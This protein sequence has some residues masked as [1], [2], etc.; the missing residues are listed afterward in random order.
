MSEK[1]KN[2]QLAELLDEL[3]ERLDE[4]DNAIRPDLPTDDYGVGE[5]SVASLVKLTLAKARAFL[6]CLDEADDPELRRKISVVAANEVVDL[7]PD[8]NVLLKGA[9]EAGIDLSDL[10]DLLGRKDDGPDEIDKALAS[11]DG[12]VI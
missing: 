11:I 8:P 9:E 7:I 6:D 1:N 12:P 5:L 2:R 10:N 4:V 3:N